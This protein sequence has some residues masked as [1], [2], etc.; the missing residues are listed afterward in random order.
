MWMNNWFL[1]IIAK[2]KHNIGYEIFYKRTHFVVHVLFH[3]NVKERERTK[4]ILI[5]FAWL[6][7]NIETLA[8]KNSNKFLKLKCV[9]R[10][11]KESSKYMVVA[12][13]DIS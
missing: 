3:I 1:A 8:E 2:Y 4:N 10:F 11:L 9:Q 5:G 6:A 13:E 12:K 7:Q